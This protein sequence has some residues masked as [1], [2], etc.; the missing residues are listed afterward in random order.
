MWNENYKKELINRRKKAVA[1]GGK[2]RIAKQHSLRKL[3]ARERIEA[4][5]DD[6]T[7]V[8]INDQITSRALDFDM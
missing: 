6:D 2:S 4:L 7:F 1:G 5:F 3:T 8:E